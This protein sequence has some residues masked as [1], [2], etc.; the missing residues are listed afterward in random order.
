MPAAALAAK[1]P[2]QK[3]LLGINKVTVLH[4]IIFRI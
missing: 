2:L 3:I 1:T 4:V